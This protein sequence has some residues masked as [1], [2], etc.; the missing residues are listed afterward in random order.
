[1]SDLPPWRQHTARFQ[2]RV[3]MLGATTFDF[4]H[5]FLD[6]LPAWPISTELSDRAALK[7]QVCLVT[8]G[9]LRSAREVAFSSSKLWLQG[10]FLLA[11]TGFRM[12][13]ELYGQLCWLEQKVLRP[14]EAG[15]LGVAHSRAVKAIFGS[16]TAIPH[17]RG[18]LGPHPLINVMDF[19]RAGEAAT[20]GVLEDY[21]F[22]CD[23]AH[24][25]YMLQS[26]LLFAGPDH[27]NWTNPTFALQA[28]A[29]LDR[30][31]VAGEA[32]IKGI[33]IVARDLMTRC[34]PE[35]RSEAASEVN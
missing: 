21:K 35:V 20:P 24:P 29:L 8:I 27:D 7:F 18:G 17:V 25:S 23:S 34:V 14:T 26:W 5:P 32:S 4:L 19:I 28:D 30:I 3:L 13:Q 11:A 16:N 10:H 9:S 6:D 31:V 22:L 15:D 12:L 33:G 1:M 2:D